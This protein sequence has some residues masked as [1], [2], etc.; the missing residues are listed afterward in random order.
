MYILIKY[1]S[2]NRKRKALRAPKSIQ[3]SVKVYTW[4]NKFKQTEYK[5]RFDKILVLVLL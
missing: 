3:N 2:R 4:N 5:F 1:P